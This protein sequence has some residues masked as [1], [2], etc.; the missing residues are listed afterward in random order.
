MYGF[1][2]GK[3]YA[4]PYKPDTQLL[5]YRKDIFEDPKYQG[6]FKSKTGKDLKVPEIYEDYVEIAKFFAKKFNSDSPV[7]FGWSGMGDKGS[8]WWWWVMRM[9]DLGGSWFD[10]NMHPN[11]N[12]EAGLKALN[13]YLNMPQFASPDF[14]QYEW[15]KSNTAFLSSKVLMMEQWPGLATMA[16]TPEGSWGKSDVVGKVG[17]GV[18]PGYNVNGKVVKGSVLGGWCIGISKYSKQPEN[19][20]KTIAWLT[21]PDGEPLKVAGGNAPCRSS[22]YKN[23]KATPDTAYFPALLDCNNMSKINSDVDAPPISAQLQDYL[24]TQINRTL[25]G[26][27]KPD[28]ALKMIDDEWTKQLKTAG[29]YK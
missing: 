7:D 20:Y 6:A 18:P 26:D 21:G 11:F 15:T 3:Q 10:A 9:S 5:F 22:T 1:W 29:L 13:D 17:Y 25:L 27:L 23:W 14:L 12:N 8:G 19:C 2:E 16:E 28:V 24:T 4:F